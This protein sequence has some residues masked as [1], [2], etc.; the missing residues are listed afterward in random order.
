MSDI[1]ILGYCMTG[2]NAQSRK[3]GYDMSSNIL[4]DHLLRRHSFPSLHFHFCAL[5]LFPGL[6][7]K[8]HTQSPFLLKYDS[9]MNFPP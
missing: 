8:G 7:V 5:F 1:K 9:T 6:D 2:G 4:S 3:A